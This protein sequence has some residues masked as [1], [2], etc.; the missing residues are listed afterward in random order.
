MAKHDIPCTNATN[1]SLA[2]EW[3]RK[4]Q[5]SYVLSRAKAIKCLTCRFSLLLYIWS[6]IYAQSYCV[7]Y[8]YKLAHDTSYNNSRLINLT[9]SNGY[10]RTVIRQLD[11]ATWRY[12]ES[13]P[14]TECTLSTTYIILKRYI[15]CKYLKH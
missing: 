5:N 2:W 4:K 11:G 12:T 6:F 9:Q 15:I 1:C 8:R 3:L 14:T 13:S 7:I 10:I